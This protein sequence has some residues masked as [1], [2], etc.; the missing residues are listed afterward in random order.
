MNCNRSFFLQAALNFILSGTGFSEDAYYSLALS[1]L[2]LT[3]GSLPEWKSPANW[4][5]Q[6]ILEPYAVLEGPGEVF[7]ERSGDSRTALRAPEGRLVKARLYVPNPDWTSMQ[8]FSFTVEPSGKSTE[9]KKDFFRAKVKHYERLLSRGIPGAAWFRHQA[10]EARKVLAGLSGEKPAENEPSPFP[11]RVRETELEET[12]NTFTGGRALSENLQ[13]DRLLAPSKGGEAS[14]DVASLQ[15]ISVAALDWKPLVKD[16][17]PQE[18]PL[19]AL[20]PA[21]QHALFV[22]SHARFD[23][24]SGC[25]RHPDPGAFGNALGGCPH[26]GALSS[27][28][29]PFG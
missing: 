5:N 17:K 24:R 13:L 8:G 16:L 10:D 1:E 12:Y 27:P 22:T 23:G 7:V 3:E 18:D 21:D 4:R 25:A 11:G 28:A 9:A 26:L 19:A 6:A 15:G 29:L 2:K 14:V 20:I